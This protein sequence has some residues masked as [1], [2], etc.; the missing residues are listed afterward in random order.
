LIVHNTL[1]PMDPQISPYPDASHGSFP[2]PQVN[3]SSFDWAL[4]HALDPR[5]VESTVNISAMDSVLNT[6][7]KCDFS[8]DS[9]IS[10]NPN[11]VKLMALIQTVL[12]Y[13]LRCQDQLKENCR[14]LEAQN[15]ELE[16]AL[17]KSHTKQHRLWSALQERQHR[18]K[19]VACG[20]EFV[21]I[22]ALDAHMERRHHNL[23]KVWMAIRRNEPC[24]VQ[25]QSTKME[26]ELAELRRT[27]QQLQKEKHAGPSQHSVSTMTDSLNMF[28]RRDVSLV[29]QPPQAVHVESE[30][31]VF[32]LPAV[33][34]PEQKKQKRVTHDVR[35]RVN[36]FLTKVRPVVPPSTIEQVAAK[37]TADLYEQ[38]Q[39][40]SRRLPSETFEEARD[41]VADGIEVL[42]P[43]PGPQPAK[44]RE[45]AAKPPPKAKPK[46]RATDALSIH[47][48]SMPLTSSVESGFQASL[49]QAEYYSRRES[50]ASASASASAAPLPT[51]DLP[52][53]GEDGEGEDEGGQGT[54]EPLD[55][56]DVTPTAAS[57]HRSQYSTDVPGS[58]E[59]GSSEPE[60][61]SHPPGILLPE[62]GSG[63]SDSEG[64]T[65]NTLTISP[66]PNNGP[67]ED[68]SNPFETDD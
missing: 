46:A 10:H 14:I 68:W 51:T 20:R 44:P 62:G 54:I 35:Q 21:S 41:R 3:V 23:Y 28:E 42:H 30:P 13:M 36:D 26:S 29:A 58:S 56:E 9:Q 11:L 12:R 43:T 55:N 63:P 24:E 48:D 40:L 66:A 7:V 5:H 52:G 2:H 4:V 47:E 38:S 6:V 25:F 37:I 59:P 61:M 64:H 39:Q 53:Q 27:V 50:S 32:V 17:E 57:D 16:S 22:S 67:D 60:P 1:S 34:V 19:C 49:N 15:Q 18:E 65:I 33:S 8:I 31:D 45:S